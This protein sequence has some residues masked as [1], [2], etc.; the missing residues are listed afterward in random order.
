MAVA[1]SERRA[2][3][4]AD[5]TWAQSARATLLPGHP[6]SIVNISRGGAL[7]EGSRPMRPGSRVMLQIVTAS[8]ALGLS[9]VILR[10]AVRILTPNDGVVYRGALKFD[11]RHDWSRE[12][13]TRPG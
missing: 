6:I 2:Y 8:A 9:A 12:L 5:E 3:E 7:V 10:C 1:V 13:H 11:E 4:R